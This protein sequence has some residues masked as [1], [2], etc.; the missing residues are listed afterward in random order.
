MET[1][2]HLYNYG[3]CAIFCDDSAY[4]GVDLPYVAIMDG[5]LLGRFP[6]DKAAEDFAVDVATY[7]HGCMTSFPNA[8]H[9]GGVS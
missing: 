4:P 3:P 2:R 5:E 1:L 8:Y 9:Y 6:T 7:Y